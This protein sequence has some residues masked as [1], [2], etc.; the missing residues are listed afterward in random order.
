V[1]KKTNASSECLLDRALG[2]KPTKGCSTNEKK[3][4]GGG[5]V[6]SIDPTCV[7]PDTAL[8]SH[9]PLLAEGAMDVPVRGLLRGGLKHL[10]I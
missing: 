6:R 10:N 1:V 9:S 8:L 5:E 3:C 4:K 7:P 2:W